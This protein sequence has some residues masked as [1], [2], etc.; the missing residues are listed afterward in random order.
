[1]IISS[2]SIPIVLRGHV[3]RCPQ[4]AKKNRGHLRRTYDGHDTADTANTPADT[5]RTLQTHTCGLVRSIMSV[6]N[7]CRL[8][9]ETTDICGHVRCVPG[10]LA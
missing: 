8:V 10:L 2:H 1:M 5:R 3:R 4:K 9:K 6:V 7:V